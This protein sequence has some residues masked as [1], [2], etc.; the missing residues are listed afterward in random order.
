M[1]SAEETC[2]KICLNI[3]QE[4]QKF[5]VSL[6]GV[7]SP[8]RRELPSFLRDFEKT[9]NESLAG[10]QLVPEEQARRTRATS[11]SKRSAGRNEPSHTTCT[12]QLSLL[13]DRLIWKS[14]TLIEAHQK[15]TSGKQYVVV[16]GVRFDLN[17]NSDGSTGTIL[18]FKKDFFEFY[19]L[20]ERTLVFMLGLFGV[21][22][23]AGY[24]SHEV[25]ELNREPDS[26]NRSTIIGDG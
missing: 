14:A 23:D 10:I 6:Q 8:A 17:A 20:L 12:D 9:Q 1:V 4:E 13:I 21:S 2:S 18:M 5:L 16:Y 19:A 26:V 11:P 22:I 25:P 7:R 3:S 15:A 24:A